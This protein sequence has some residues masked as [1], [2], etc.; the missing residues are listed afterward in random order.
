MKVTQ[1]LVNQN[2]PSKDRKST[3]VSDRKGMA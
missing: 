1:R 3:N 2:K